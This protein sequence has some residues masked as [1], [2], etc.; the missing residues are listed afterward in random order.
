MKRID[1]GDK[2]IVHFHFETQ[3]EL[4][5]TFIR[6]QEFYESPFDGIRGQYFTLDQY[7][8]LY[9]EKHG[10]FT[11]LTDWA[12]FN[13]PGNVVMDFYYKF[14]G[15]LRDRELSLMNTV[16]GRFQGSSE[17]YVIGTYGKSVEDAAGYVDHEIAHAYYYLSPEF[18]KAQDAVYNAM[19]AE[20]KAKVAV[21]LMEMGYDERV[22][23]DETQAYFSTDEEVILR[24]RFDLT[25]EE[26]AY[27]D[28]F[29]ANLREI[30]EKEKA[31]A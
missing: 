28:A 7:M 1:H 11:Y 24:N 14:D 18:K 10:A 25:A 21:Y 31:L 3:H 30:R 22:I 4:C 27:R 26:A 2:R 15:R 8:D 16:N 6:L 29:S 20:V 23:L 19:N 17:F 12:G 13:V 9:A 5:S